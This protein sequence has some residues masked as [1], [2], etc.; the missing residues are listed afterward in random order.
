MWDIPDETGHFAYTRNIGS[1]Q[2]I[3]LLGEAEIDVDILSNVI[4]KPI[5]KPSMNWIAQHPPIYY[6]FSG[7]VWK[8]TSIF[9]SNPEILFRA[10]RI[11]S[12]LFGAATLII[13]YKLFLLLKVNPIISLA[14]MASV[15]FIPMF[16][17]LSSGINH[18]TAVTFFSTLSIYY[19]ITF[20]LNKKNVN[21]YKSAFWISVAA[22]TKM[23]ALVILAPMIVI[24]LLELNS[25]CKQRI[26]EFFLILITSL[27]SPSLWML[28]QYK[29]FH[30]P[31]ATAISISPSRL[32]E[33]LQDSYLNYFSKFA[34][35]EHFFKNFFG[36]FGWIGTGEGANVWFQIKYLPLK[37]YIVILLIL[38][39]MTTSLIIKKIIK[40]VFIS[41]QIKLKENISIIDW[42]KKTILLKVN[43]KYLSVIIITTSLI[44]T[45]FFSF[46]SYLSPGISNLINHI[47]F[48]LL[49][50][51]FLLSGLLLLIPTNKNWK[52]ISY[53]L[54]IF[55][56]FTLVTTFQVYQ[57]YLNDGRLRATHGRYFYPLFSFLLIGLIYPI[58]ELL[59]NKSKFFLLTAIILCFVEF[60]TFTK[61]VFPFY[62]LGYKTL[63]SSP[64]SINNKPAGEITKNT[65][66]EQRVIIDQ[67]SLEKLNDYSNR[68]N[69]VC[70]SLS[71]ANYSNRKNTGMIKVDFSNKRIRDSKF[72]DIS[73]IKDNSFHTICFDDFKISDLYNDVHFLRIKGVDSLP[74]QSITAWLTEDLIHPH[75]KINQN[76]IE[77]NL[78]FKILI[79][80]N[81]TKITLIYTF[82]TFIYCTTTILLLLIL[83]FPNNIKV[84]E[85]KF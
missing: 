17:H 52:L 31:F 5:D 68:D 70:A 41:S 40:N 33:P 37:I 82:F 10:P 77:K 42:L 55:G 2:G 53:S 54:L 74:G 22:T 26:K 15:S 45:I 4:H 76:Q 34:I 80:E 9:T 23:T 1:G 61:Q 69:N 85:T 66:I 36:L 51:I 73:K 43:L 24:M 6:F 83:I 27:L 56:F 57:L 25:A 20:L 62:N 21:A 11:A 47:N 79:K 38:L 35:F 28:R 72:I 78:M 32:T 63:I 64:E 67:K 18:D 48:T 8:I 58:I 44:L 3:P 30:N 13:I 60:L 19:W 7:A 84:K 75:I 46:T 12:A 71:L 81:N 59:K 49:I 29:Y 39:I 65:V 50:F 14:I 16:S